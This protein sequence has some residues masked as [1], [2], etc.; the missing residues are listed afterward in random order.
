[1]ASQLILVIEDDPDIQELIQYNLEREGFRVSF[2]DSGEVGLKSAR[3]TTPALIILDLVLPGIQ[4][5]DVCRL[6]KQHRETAAVPIIMLTARGEESDI[7]VGLELGADD[8]I[9]K[10]FR[11]REL[12]ARIKAVLRRGGENRTEQSEHLIKAGPLVIDSGR[13][14]VILKQRPV[15]MTLAEFRTLKALAARPGRVLTRDQILNRVTEGKTFI[16]D[17]NVDVHIRSIRRKLGE[18]RD[19]IETIRGVGY[20]FRDPASG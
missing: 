18:H 16:I 5:R 10:P 9:T 17:R 7:V 15:P 19:L 6:L 12:V 3:E 13:H 11:V 14:E 8:Y 20:K 4:G 1:M 2:A